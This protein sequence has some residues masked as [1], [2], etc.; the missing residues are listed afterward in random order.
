[1]IALFNGKNIAY[2]TDVKIAKKSP[3]LE[4]F[5]PLAFWAYLSL[6]KNTQPI[7]TAKVPYFS[8][9][10][11][12]CHMDI[13][14]RIMKTP[15]RAEKMRAWEEMVSQADAIKVLDPKLNTIPLISN[16]KIPSKVAMYRK[17]MLS[18]WLRIVWNTKGRLI[19]KFV[20]HLHKFFVVA[21]ISPYKLKKDGTDAPPNTAANNTK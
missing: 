6:I 20:W 10:W 13:L 5:C 16:G 18:G 11:T 2:Q 15:A 9:L 17:S 3:S 8:R 12:S 4:A 19:R 21:L 1:M 7:M 14:A